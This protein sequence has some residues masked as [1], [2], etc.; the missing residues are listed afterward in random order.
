MKNLLLLPLFI[1]FIACSQNDGSKTS[2]QAGSGVE[3]TTTTAGG[4]GGQPNPGY[5]CNGDTTD[6]HCNKQSCLPL[7]V[8]N[9]VLP[10]KMD[11]KPYIGTYN[12]SMHYGLPSVA[13]AQTLTTNGGSDAVFR[14]RFKVEP[15]P[16]IS[17]CPLRTSGSP[18]VPNYNKLRI[19]FQFFNINNGQVVPVGTP[20][21]TDPV[22]VG[23]CSQVIDLPYSQMAGAFAGPVVLGIKD[24][25]SDWECFTYG[26]SYV[27][28]RC[29]AEIE[30]TSKTCWSVK[31]QVE[32][33]ATDTFNY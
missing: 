3:T 5:S 6:G 26:D 23:S 14:V 24:V 16:D 10:G 17:Q 30:V 29:P 28:T 22:N 25:K 15:Q 27:A 20:Y 4:G 9:V 8:R 12:A 32:T 21:T 33:D 7:H 2:N 13:E 18:T 11:W 19:T 31:L 1:F